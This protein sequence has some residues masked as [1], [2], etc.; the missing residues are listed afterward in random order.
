MVH[1]TFGNHEITNGELID[2]NLAHQ[3]IFISWNFLP[4]K[5]Y[6]LLIYDIDVKDKSPFCHTLIINIPGMNLS[7]GNMI[8]SYIPP[9]PPLN[10]LPHQYYINIYEQNI[11]IDPNIKFNREKFD[12]RMFVNKYELKLYDEFIFKVENKNKIKFSL[13]QKTTMS[14]YPKSLNKPILPMVPLTYSSYKS[15]VSPNLSRNVMSPQFKSSSHRHK[16]SG[17]QYF[18]ESSQLTEEEEKYCR[19]IL[20]VASEQP[21]QCNMEKAWFEKRDDR[22]CYNP[23][24]VCASRVGGSNKNCSINYQFENFP[25]D[26]LRAYA[27]LHGIKSPTPYSKNKMLDA[28]YEWKSINK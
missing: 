23:Y 22:I 25:D 6:T 26:E 7:K 18:K 10:S 24:A 1:V 16:H 13:N 20:H 17:V 12:I 14:Q 28:I 2:I 4:D 3:N 19:C 5:S 11:Y 15:P 8:I 21:G 9:S 27:N